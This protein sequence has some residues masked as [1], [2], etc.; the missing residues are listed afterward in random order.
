MPNWRNRYVFIV[1]GAGYHQS[2]EF[3]NVASQLGLPYM[4][5]S[6]YSY[7][8]APCETYFAHLKKGVW[9]PNNFKTSKT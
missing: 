2:K 8:A 4:I 9:N 1:D 3:L 7:E 6:P 5:L